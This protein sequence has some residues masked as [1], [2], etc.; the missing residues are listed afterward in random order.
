MT[1]EKDMVSAGEKMAEHSHLIWAKKVWNDLNTKGGFLPTILVPWDLLT[2]FERRKDRFRATEILKFVQYHGYHVESP[3]TEQSLDRAKSEGERSSVEKRTL[4]KTNSD[5]IRTSLLTFFNNCADDLFAG[6]ER[7]KGQRSV[8]THPR[9]KS[10]VMDLPGVC[11]P[12]DHTMDDIQAAGYKILDSLY[13]VTGLASTAAQ[14]KS[15]GYETDKHRPGLGQCLSAFASCFPVAFLEPEYNKNN[16]Y[17]VL[18]KTQDQSV[19][20][21]VDDIQAAGYKILDSLYMVTG[22]ASTAAQRKSIGYETDKHRPGLGQCLSAF[23]SCFPVAFLEP[24]Y[25]KNNKYSVLAKTQDQSVQVQEMLQ[26]LS[27]HIPH[28]EKL[29]TAI[30]Q[31]SS[32]GITYAE[33]PNV[34]DVDLPLMCSYLAYWFNQGPDGRKPEKTEEKEHKQS[35]PMT[36]VS[37]E[38]INRIFCALLRMLRNHIGVENAPW[39]CRTNFFA[40]QI[41]QNVTCDPV[42]DYILP[43]AERLRRMSEKAFKEEEHMRTHPDRR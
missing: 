1:L 9:S 40:V 27:T 32:N 6:R 20:V 7:A 10:E 41:I 13:M 35:L 43:I 29:L 31:V 3:K 16:K 11:S 39:L 36:S 5:I 14:R 33:Q 38:H 23:A 26:N 17:S 42:K 8:L 15:I 25:N 30:E 19:Q 34:Y 12:D 18:A 2:D 37:A 4:V 28:I 24:E 22:L 21:Q